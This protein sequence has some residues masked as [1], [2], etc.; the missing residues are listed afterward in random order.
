MD[1][2]RQR[3]SRITSNYYLNRPSIHSHSPPQHAVTSLIRIHK[4]YSSKH[5][6]AII[7]LILYKFD[8]DRILLQWLTDN[9]NPSPSLCLC[10]C[11]NTLASWTNSCTHPDVVADRLATISLVHESLSEYTSLQS[12]ILES[13]QLNSEPLWRGIWSP[14]HTEAITNLLIN[15]PLSANNWLLGHRLMDKVTKILSSGALQLHSKFRSPYLSARNRHIPSNSI[16]NL[17]IL[18]NSLLHDTRILTYT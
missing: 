14:T 1:I 15:T 10:G 5:R 11:Y 8:D 9:S 4:A 3:N 17:P 6:S 2:S 12:Y 13:L 16:V 7:K 18:T